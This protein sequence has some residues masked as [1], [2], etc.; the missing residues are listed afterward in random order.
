MHPPDR[1]RARAADDGPAS[2]SAIAASNQGAIISA[3]RTHGPMS[4]AR[5]SELTGLSA[6]TVNRLV[7]VLGERGLLAQTGVEASSGGRPPVVLG[8]VPEAIVVGAVQAH[9]DRVIGALVGFD[10]VILDR[11]VES[12]ARPGQ[13]AG[14][15]CLTRMVRW[16]LDRGAQLGAPVQGIGVSLAGVTDT[17]GPV[18]GLDARY[19]PELE[20]DE[21]TGP[22]DVPITV[23]NDANVLAI[24]ELHRGVGRVTPYFVALVLDRGLGSGIVA[25]GALLRG[26]RSAAGEVGYLLLGSDSL[27]V[28][29][30]E[31]GE[32]EAV[33]EPASVTAAA[34]RAGIACEAPITAPEIIAMSIDGDARADAAANDV[35]DGLARAIAALSSIL[36]PAC[37]VLGEGLDHR[38]DA[39]IPALRR[40]IEGRIQFVPEVRTASLG[41]DAVLLGA[42]EMALRDSGLAVPLA[43]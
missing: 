31:H 3:L 8:V 19:W 30:Q 21:V 1:T 13:D 15:E 22:F 35:L 20:I 33:L 16:L 2:T 25:N 36:D 43:P 12:I 34:V 41:A 40:R 11:H 9:Q 23:E 4:K 10:G 14:P 7:K 24:G 37:I 42:A 38:A 27:R 6:A 26:A 18:T 5:I 17:T 28:N 29:P 39:V 32:L